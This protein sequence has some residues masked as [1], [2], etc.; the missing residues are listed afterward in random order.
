VGQFGDLLSL[1]SQKLS[2]EC[3]V[4]TVDSGMAAV[5][6]KLGSSQRELLTN[7]HHDVD[8]DGGD[9]QDILEVWHGQ[10]SSS[11]VFRFPLTLTSGLIL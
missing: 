6:L 1:N 8:G 5:N 2:A 3:S 11:A 7:C 4:A 10:T 9:K